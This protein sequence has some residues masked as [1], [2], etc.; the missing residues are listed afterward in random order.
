MFTITEMRCSE[1]DALAKLLALITGLWDERVGQAV[2][3]GTRTLGGTVLKMLGR[4]AVPL[5][6]IEYRHEPGEVESDPLT[7]FSFPT[8]FVA[9][10][11]FASL[12]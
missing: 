3:S 10:A 9:P 1:D 5:V 7:W 12:L 2:L 8:R 6:C 11:L 4:Y